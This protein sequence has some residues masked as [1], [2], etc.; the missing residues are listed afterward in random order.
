MKLHSLVLCFEGLL[1][2]CGHHTTPMGQDA[3]TDA[4]ADHDA[5]VVVDGGMAGVGMCT[6]LAAGLTC[7]TPFC[8]AGYA[9]TDLGALGAGLASIA[10]AIDDAGNVT[11]RYRQT[12]GDPRTR[13]FRWSPRGGFVDLGTLG[14]D[15]SEGL[16]VRGERVVGVSDVAPAAS[17]AFLSD[18]GGIHD[19]GTL[20]GT[21]SIARSINAA[22]IAVGE[23]RA[24]NNVVRATRYRNGAVDDLGTLAGTPT[25]S[26]AAMAIND[27]GVIVGRSDTATG[28]S[29]AARWANDTVVDLGT[30]GASP[31]IATAVNSHGDAAGSVTNGAL[32]RPAR[33]AGGTV[34]ALGDPPG[35]NSGT[36]TGI[37]NAGVIVGNSRIVTAEGQGAGPPFVFDG[38]SMVALD[39]LLPPDP[40]PSVRVSTANA[41]NNAGQIAGG[42]D[43]GAVVLAPRC[44][45]APPFLSLVSA[46]TSKV[47]APGGVAPGDLL[48]AALKYAGDPVA[49]I[50]PQGWLLVVDQLAG[51]GTDLAFHALVYVH[52]ATAAEPL[53]YTFEAPEGV[54]VALQIAAYR[55][56]S[57]VDATAARGSVDFAISAPS[58]T[59]TQDNGVLIAIFISAADDKWTRAADQLSRLTQRSNV[60]GI[61]L[62]DELRPTAG[63]T[64]TPSSVTTSGPIA[65]ISIALR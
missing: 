19:L 50:P 33:F 39:D 44:S 31:S 40:V 13:A 48:L 25:A 37:N 64:G 28:Q 43:R 61:S 55:A 60:D 17:H 56:L 6:G 42:A 2:A 11:G 24:A 54:R 7:S 34:V 16:G 46:R 5:D 36:A 49:V 10:T 15:S 29:H 65:A 32:S 38:K 45:P 23:S 58:V 53:G 59:T 9:V 20:G 57:T 30:L 8:A 3:S 21:A 47:A 52:I 4:F 51:A 41:I 14:G 26:S 27:G 12:L 1:V 62:Q 18:E 35:A 63:Q 22:G